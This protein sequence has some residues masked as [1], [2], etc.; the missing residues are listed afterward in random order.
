MF[1]G[2]FNM[3]TNLHRQHQQTTYDTRYHKRR[4][5]KKRIAKRKIAKMSRRK[6]YQVLGKRG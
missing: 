2:L 3:F 4:N 6:N 5:W 1:H